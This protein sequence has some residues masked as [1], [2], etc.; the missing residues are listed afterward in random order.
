LRF[1]FVS[2]FGDD[3]KEANPLQ[4]AIQPESDPWTPGELERLFAEH[5]DLVF[6]TAY[7]ITGNLMDAEDVL[8]T[9]FLRLIRRETAVQMEG[10]RSYLHRA[11][12]NAALDIVRRRSRIRSV[13]LDDDDAGRIQNP[14]PDPSAICSNSDLHAWLRSRIAELNPRAAEIFVLRYLQGCS[15]LEIAQ[16]LGIPR[17]TVAVI[18]HRTRARLQNELRSFLGGTQ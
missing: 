16:T 1:T 12:V 9:L 6:R 18:L 13:S 8:Q 5:H 4:A 7:R 11:A 3:K 15:Y 2:V 10:A 17:P 14:R